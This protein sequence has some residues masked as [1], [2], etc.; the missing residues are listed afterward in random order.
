M[1]QG[2]RAPLDQKR[3][4]V[5]LYSNVAQA[6]MNMHRLDDAVLYARRAVDLGRS[7]DPSGRLLAGAL[8]LLAN[9]L[10][11]AG[12][13]DGAL[14][15]IT[16]ARRVAENATFA[17]EAVRVAGLYAILWRQGV[18][19]GDG[20]SISLDRPVEAIEP[21]QAAFDL[22]ERQASRDPDDMA[23]R[24]LVAT[25]ARQLGGV[26]RQRDP[27]RALAV[28]DRGLMR[29]REIKTGVKARR[30]EARLLAQSSYPLRSLRR[31]REAKDRI[32]A[33]FELLR[34]IK[35]YPA[36]QVELGGEA[37][38]AIRA[39]ADHEADTGRPE[40]ALEIY[41]DLLDKVI[42]AKP[43]PE[44]N[45]GQANDLS[46]IYVSMARLYRGVGNTIEADALTARRLELWR[47][48]DQKLPH[49]PFVLRQL[50][51]SPDRSR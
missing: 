37:E 32:D 16:E 17:N 12:D 13:L 27:A 1:L 48:W 45:L 41:R 10:R 21:L 11:Q 51:A 5:G 14:Q 6:Y 34:A 26:L 33:A 20:D 29:L 25:A 8:S 31:Y 39:L 44:S 24:D 47:A 22:V 9:A 2:G 15:S 50:A 46:R 40:R 30:Q 43:N 7:A 3:G 23:G 49:N 42:A 4:M 28:Y 35:D 18:I 19:L 36:A 38:A